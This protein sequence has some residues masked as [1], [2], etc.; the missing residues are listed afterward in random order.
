MKNSHYFFNPFVAMTVFLTALNDHVLKYQYSSFVTGILS[1]FTG[2]F[3]FPLLVAVIFET[4]KSFRLNCAQFNWLAFVTGLLSITFKFIP[5][6]R[7]A[8]VDFF[9]EHM[10]AITIVSDPKD[11]LALL[12]LPLVCAWFKAH[13]TNGDQVIN[14]RVGFH[15]FS[16]NFNF[17]R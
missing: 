13:H 11:L 1:D 8:L 15:L 2:L 12:S 4:K 5:L 14:A 6:F 10:F 7:N 17:R 16:R 3:F 9:H